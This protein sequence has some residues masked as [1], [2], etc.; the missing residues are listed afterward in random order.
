MHWTQIG[1]TLFEVWRDEGAPK[2]TV[3]NDAADISIDT[4]ATCEAINSLKFY[5]G[6]FD[7]EWGKDVVAG[8]APWHDLEQAEFAKWL[9][10][11][12]LDYNDTKLS[13]GY[14]PIGKVLL[15][16]SFGTTDKFEIWQLLE[17]H[18]D[19]YKIEVDGITQIYDYCW[20]DLD[21]QEQQINMLKPGY[22][23]QLRT[24]K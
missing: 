8:N 18:L 5:S 17:Q 13:L 1:K 16:E 15:Q 11:N 14:L 7:I 6:E 20:T 4:G 19:I 10:S 21:Y 24:L 23:Y 22:D 12:G 3:G 2:L 9:D